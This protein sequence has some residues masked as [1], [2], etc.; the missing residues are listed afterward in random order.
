MKTIYKY[1]LTLM[2]CS[3]ITEPV[4]MPCDARYLHVDTQNG[5]IFIWAEVDTELSL[6]EHTF[7]IYG[8]GQ[9]ICE[10]IGI[11]REHINSLIIRERNLVLHV[12][13]RIN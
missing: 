10:D 2:P 8:T 11:E 9:E 12:Y 1:E 4:I 13:H 5:G 7:E 3:S 6:V